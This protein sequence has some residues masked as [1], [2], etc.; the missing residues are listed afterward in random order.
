MLEA[1]KKH[2]IILIMIGFLLIVTIVLLIM[3]ESRQNAGKVP[4]RG[5][6]VFND[7]QQNMGCKY[8]RHN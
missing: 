5:V 3:L 8:L 7:F 4:T 6:F 2:K 1:I